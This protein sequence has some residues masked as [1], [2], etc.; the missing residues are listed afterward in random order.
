MTSGC[1]KRRVNMKIKKIKNK[2][3]VGPIQ[4]YS[5]K[6]LSSLLYQASYRRRVHDTG[7]IIGSGCRTEYCAIDKLLK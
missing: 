4:N 3:G 5:T 1:Q 7:P 2:K 6:V